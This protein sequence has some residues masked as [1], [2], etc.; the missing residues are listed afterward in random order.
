[1]TQQSSSAFD[2]ITALCKRRGFIFQ[3]SLIYGGFANTWDYG[4]YGVELK[5]NVKRAW[6]NTVV[7]DRDDMY[8]MDS[9]ILMHPAIWRA[10][11]H[12]DNFYDYK[13]DCKRCKHRFKTEDLIDKEKCPD[14]GGE[15]TEG[16]AFNLMF[17][18]HQGVVEDATSLVYLR[19][20]T[21]QGIFVN[22]SN[23]LD[24]HHPKL[25]FGIA[26]IGKAFRNEITPGNF[27]FRTR[28][29]EQM[30]IEYF[31]RPEDADRA[32]EEWVNE[33]LSWYLRH[34]IKKENLRLAPHPKEKLA[35]YATAC[36]DVEYQF[37]FGWAELEGI[38]NRTDFDLKQHASSSGKDL[39]YFDAGTTTRYFP[40][41]IEPS[42][43]V[44]RSVLAFLLDA[45]HE[46]EVNGTLRVVL[47]L[48]RALAPVKIAV[49]PLLKKRP[50]LVEKARALVTAL[51]KRFYT[52]YDDTAAIGKLYR[53]Q[54]EVG[55]P[56]CITVDVESLDDNK[57]TVRDRDTMQQERIGIDGIVSYFNDRFE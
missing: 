48:H 36:T 21:A 45:Y 40:F 47:K 2:K 46:E 31:V 55:T 28:E 8:G 37:P 30:E 50:E 18:T 16:R 33:R 10:S 6:W 57:V 35:H 12:V 5:N 34:G 29:F 39:R 23:V 11:G 38:A 32:Y 52:V 20:E 4:P 51:N 53:R 26:Q 3:S 24:T 41:V 9:A 49:F 1:M 22:Y 15:L 13:S 42:A 27:T 54:D 44:D 25:P 43:G 7:H 56:Y 19:P 17:Q 14:C